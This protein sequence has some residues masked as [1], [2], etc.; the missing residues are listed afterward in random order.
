VGRGAPE[1]TSSPSTAPT[2]GQSGPTAVTYVLR[3]H[4]RGEPSALAWVV[5]VPA[6][7]LN[8]LAHAD[9]RLFDQLAQMTEPQ[10]DIMKA[11][12]GGS[13][14]G[15]GGALGT[16]EQQGG[17]V[18]VE[19]RG[20]AGILDWA[21]LTSSGADALL[22]WLNENDFDVPAEAASIL[23]TYI[24]QDMHFLAVR[25][26]APEQ[27]TA[28]AT[29]AIDIPP[30]Q[31]TCVTSQVFYPMAISRIS[32]ADPTEVL[33]YLMGYERMEA[34]NLPN[35]V[36]DPNALAYDPNSPSLTNYESLFTDTIAELGGAAL[37]T[38]YANLEYGLVS[39]GLTTVW[40]DAPAGTDR[41]DYL[42]RLRTVLP[43]ERMDQDFEFQAAA[44]NQPV[45]SDFT[46][47]VDETAVAS[48]LGDAAVVAGLYGVFCQLL[49]RRAA[50]R[51][52]GPAA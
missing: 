1:T 6:T 9:A 39:P 13:G 19:S 31:F 36:I 44:S 40:P 25:I 18:N 45:S 52:S 48:L 38:E 27:L 21:A 5:P 17:L 8:V 50:K 14:C 34:A 4:Y 51:R 47:T 35:G 7:P 26:N 15:C 41:L 42:T 28:D 43:R 12:S 3:T 10:F 33:L 16:A 30:L 11:P 20:T 37:I 32:A 46:L 24:A 2:E 22:T 29:G 49:K 23:D